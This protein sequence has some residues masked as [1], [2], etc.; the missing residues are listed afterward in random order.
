MPSLAAGFAAVNASAASTL[1][2]LC[3]AE[4]G[5]PPSTL[6]AGLWQS[7]LAMLAAVSDC[8]GR[9]VDANA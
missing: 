3:F 9:D 1:Q 6:A 2:L 5:G 7:L 8:G 4:K